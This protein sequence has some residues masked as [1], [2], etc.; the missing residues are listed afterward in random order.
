MYDNKGRWIPRLPNEPNYVRIKVYSIKATLSWMLGGFDE[1]VILKDENETPLRFGFG[2]DP[3]AV[4]NLSL[5][6][7]VDVNHL[8]IDGALTMSDIQWKNIVRRKNSTSFTLM[9]QLG[10]PETTGQQSSV[11]SS[12]RTRMDFR[13]VNVNVSSTLGNVHAA[14]QA[15]SRRK[16]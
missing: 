12:P 4:P 2:L 9:L 10:V 14:I 13:L 7:Q 8:E 15:E 5:R 3:V 6:D 11:L 16:E 1:L